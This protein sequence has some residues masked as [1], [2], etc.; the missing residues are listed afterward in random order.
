MS[1]KR[2]NEKHANW[3]WILRSLYCYCS[4]LSNDDIISSRSGL[5]TG[6]KNDVFW[7]EIGRHA[8]TRIPWSTP[9]PPGVTLVAIC[10]RERL[11]TSLLLTISCHANSVTLKSIHH[12]GIRVHLQKTKHCTDMP[13]GNIHCY[14]LSL[15]ENYSRQRRF[16][17]GLFP[18]PCCS[19]RQDTGGKRGEAGA[20]DKVIFRKAQSRGQTPIFV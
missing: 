1:I 10:V 11:T 15:Y 2:K 7:S 6:V 17:S 5:K 20:L 3:K 14:S 8:S 18:G 9:S 12:R 16:S 13:W 19:P 4:I